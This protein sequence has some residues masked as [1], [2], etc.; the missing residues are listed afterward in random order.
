[1]GVGGFLG[2]GSGVGCYKSSWFSAMC[3]IWFMRLPQCDS[4][5]TGL[6][7]VCPSQKHI[8]PWICKDCPVSLRLTTLE[9][10]ERQQTEQ[11]EGKGRR[12]NK[13]ID[14]WLSYLMGYDSVNIPNFVLLHLLN[15]YIYIY[16]YFINW[17]MLGQKHKGT[18]H[19]YTHTHWAQDVNCKMTTVTTV[20]ATLIDLSRWSSG[21]IRNPLIGFK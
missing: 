16:I 1:M 8:T 14:L 6:M 7:F 11:S 18:Q 17:G 3:N 19:K 15:W 5:D 9:K 21:N 13:R 4:E 10:T 12:E 2:W 20:T